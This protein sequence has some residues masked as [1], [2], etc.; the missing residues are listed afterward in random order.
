MWDKQAY[1]AVPGGRIYN[2]RKVGVYFLAFRPKV[3]RNQLIFKR[4]GL[5]FYQPDVGALQRNDDRN[6]YMLWAA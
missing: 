2:R 6:V 4:R 1:K 3:L 5:V